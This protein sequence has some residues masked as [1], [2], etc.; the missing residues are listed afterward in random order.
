MAGIVFALSGY[1]GAHVEQI[2]QLQGLAWMPWLFFLFH[3]TL[4]SQ[5]RIRWGLLLA[6]GLAL[7]IF[8]G[9]T[10]TFFTTGFGLGLYAAVYGLIGV[11]HYRVRRALSLRQIVH[12]MGLPILTLFLAVIV[13]LLLAIPQILPTLELTGMSNRGGGFTSNQATA[14]SLPP[15]YLGRALLPSYDGQLFGEYIGYV[16]VIALGLAIL[17]MIAPVNSEMRESGQGTPSP[18]TVKTLWLVVGLVGLIFAI[19]RFNPLYWQI[20]DLPGFNFF[21]V[22]ARWLALFVLSLSLFSG[23]GLHILQTQRS[24]RAQIVMAGAVLLVLMS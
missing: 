14:F 16:G 4:T 5:Q 24:T 12:S 21:R 1:L 8:S 17:G 10:Q 6:I 2:N 9:H 18:Y 13:A 23:M 3:Q 20:A 15:H 11:W 19:G 22:P 7:Q